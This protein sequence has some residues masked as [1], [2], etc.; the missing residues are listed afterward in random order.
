MMKLQKKNIT[1]LL[2][3][4]FD[5]NIQGRRRNYFTAACRGIPIMT[6]LRAHSECRGIPFLFLHVEE[7]NIGLP[8]KA[9]SGKPRPAG[10]ALS[11]VKS[12]VRT[13][14]GIFDIDRTPPLYIARLMINWLHAS[15]LIT[16]MTAHVGSVSQD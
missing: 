10:L 4:I 9:G 5:V 12:I 11:S 15:T 8:R 13:L 7:Q 16:I 3:F 6:I 1:S 14:R 2:N